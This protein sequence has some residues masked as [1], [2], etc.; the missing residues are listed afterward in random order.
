[1]RNIW[2]VEAPNALTRLVLGQQLPPLPDHSVA[3]TQFE[4]PAHSAAQLAAVY[5][6]PPPLPVLRLSARSK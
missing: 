6:L 2:L 4:V 1:M 5:P 3:A